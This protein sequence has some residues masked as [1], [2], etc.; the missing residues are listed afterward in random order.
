MRE[1]GLGFAASDAAEVSSSSQDV[2][3]RRQR[4]PH[5]RIQL[6]LTLGICLVL[7]AVVYSPVR[8]AWEV[9]R[10][11]ILVNR[12][13]VQ[14]NQRSTS[15][16]ANDLK[17]A[18]SSMEAAASRKPAS[19]L[20]QASIWRAYGEAA[21]LLPSEHSYEQMLKAR[22]TGKLDSFGELSLGEVAASTEHWDVAKQA[23]TRIDAS[24]LLINRAEKSL[25]AGNNSQAIQEY[26]LAKQSLDAAYKR[27]AAKALLLDR[28][29]SKESSPGSLAQ[30]PGEKAT[31][32]YKI[33]RGILHA[34]NAGRAAPILD[35]A[36]RAAEDH[37]PGIVME[38]SICF[39]LAQALATSLSPEAAS[40]AQAA[41]AHPSYLMIDSSKYS[42]THTIC[43]ARAITYRGLKL[44]VTAQSSLQAGKILLA[45]GDDIDGVLLI[46][47]A[48][49]LNPRYVEAYLTLG[50][51]YESVGMPVTARQLY[52]KASQLLPSNADLLNTYVTACYRTMDPQDVIPIVEKALTSQARN[53]HLYIVIGDCYWDLKLMAKARAVYEQGLKAYPNSATLSARLRELQKRTGS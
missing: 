19:P 52:K 16:T 51:R 32:L 8:Q 15:A 5:F 7:L 25:E 20:G 53:A 3:P 30:Q 39:A 21:S 12:A 33:G 24:N 37:S 50:K 48:L 27:S 35:E 31:F 42:T 18:M 22:N 41:S 40:T 46:Q 28:T 11:G 36:L 49:D 10:A 9:N 6:G 2:D 29:G 44:G 14:K 47:Q 34:G 17:K 23:F 4:I 1:S 38:Q 45:I 26:L 43:R 13:I